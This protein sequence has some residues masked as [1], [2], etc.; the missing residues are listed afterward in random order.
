MDVR[1]AM[2]SVVSEI[3]VDGIAAAVL[4]FVPRYVIQEMDVCLEQVFVALLHSNTDVHG[5]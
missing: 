3:D 1:S 2:F 5:R 4:L